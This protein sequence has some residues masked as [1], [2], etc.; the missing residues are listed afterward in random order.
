MDVN[1]E[2]LNNVVAN[3]SQSTMTKQNKRVPELY[4]VV[5]DSVNGDGTVTAHFASDVSTQMKIPNLSGITPT[6][7]KTAYV[8]T[9]GGKNMTGSFVVAC[10]GTATNSLQAQSL[11]NDSD[12]DIITELQN[13]VASLS[14]TISE[15]ESRIS[16]LESQLSTN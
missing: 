10:R 1:V 5:V 14:Q 9:T 11:D 13:Q 15:L 7:G 12:A 3:I 4:T 6:A 2:Q 16:A 8:I